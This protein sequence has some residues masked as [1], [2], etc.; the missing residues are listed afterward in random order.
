MSPDRVER[1]K[2]QV[3]GSANVKNLEKETEATKKTEKEQTLT[4]RKIKRPRPPSGQVNK[5]FLKGMITQLYWLLLMDLITT[6]TELT[7][8][9]SIVETIVSSALTPSPP[10]PPPLH[11]IM[12]WS[13]YVAASPAK[14]FSVCHPAV[15]LTCVL[16]QHWWAPPMYQQ[17]C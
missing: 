6:K 15:T 1:L 17:L 3:L 2:G 9:F 8:G 11:A 5:D 14:H 13:A 12:A 4:R 7:I 10:S 16:M